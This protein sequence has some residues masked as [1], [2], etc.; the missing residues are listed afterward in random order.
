[1]RSRRFAGTDVVAAALVAGIVLSSVL[2][3]PAAAA[4]E[5][6]KVKTLLLVGGTIHDWKGIGD[7]LGDYL[8]KSGKF[9]VT[10]V[11]QDLNAL[12]ADRVAPYDLVVFYW[13]VGKITDEQRK[14][15]LDHIAK[16]KGFVTLHSGADSFRGDQEWRNF[17]G[18]YF[19]TH[20]S[21]R[22]YHVSMIKVDHPIT[23]G[24]K[25]YLTTD[26]QYILNYGYTKDLT[27]LANGLHEGKVMPVIWTKPWGKG[28]VFYFA[29]GHDAKACK[30]A[31]VK[32]I[33]LRGCLWAAQRKVAD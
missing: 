4:A 17:V 24:I 3:A 7:V 11:D 19:I 32:R 5:A 20:P 1:M 33:F 28:R 25:E 30:Q 29:Q 2:V 23:A 9:D 14:G 26:E 27:I 15:L 13:T 6:G 12:L 22:M 31:M 16:G 8:E 10:R 21:Y 18:G